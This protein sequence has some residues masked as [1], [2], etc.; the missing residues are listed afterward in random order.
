MIPLGSLLEPVETFTHQLAFMLILAHKAQPIAGIDV[1]KA[2]RALPPLCSERRIFGL[3]EP[4]LIPVTYLSR[5]AGT[6]LLIGGQRAR[7]LCR[8]LHPVH[9]VG[10]I[11][12]LG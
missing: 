5:G 12:L 10:V 3:T 11:R 8:L 1:A 2:S 7:L 6:D 9:G 4:S